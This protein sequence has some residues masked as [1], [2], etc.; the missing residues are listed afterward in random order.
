ML[1]SQCLDPNVRGKQNVLYI[2][3]G[4]GVDTKTRWCIVIH[5]FS[6]RILSMS[7]IYLVGTQ[8]PNMVLHHFPLTCH[9]SQLI[10]TGQE[11][12][13]PHTWFLACIH[14]SSNSAYHV[15]GSGRGAWRHDHWLDDILDCLDVSLHLQAPA[16]MSSRQNIDSPSQATHFKSSFGCD[17]VLT[18]HCDQDT[19]APLVTLKMSQ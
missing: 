3:K 16:V 4:R 7:E 10:F 5:V 6:D 17:I 18:L 1:H 9:S 14:V 19:T 2:M 15:S 11:I 8:H 12:R 13:Y